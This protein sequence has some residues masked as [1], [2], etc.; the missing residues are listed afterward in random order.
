M[1]VVAI[2]SFKFVI[3]VIFIFIRP[4]NLQRGYLKW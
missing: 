1:Y 3:I 2:F 4:L